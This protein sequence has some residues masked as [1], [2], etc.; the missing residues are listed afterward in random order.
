[1]QSDRGTEFV[2]SLLTDFLAVLQVR[3]RVSPA[4][5]LRV[6]G[7]VERSNRTMA[8]LLSVMVNQ[9]VRDHLVRWGE[10]Q[11]V[12][13][14]Q[15]RLSQVSRSGLTPHSLVHGWAAAEAPQRAI[16]PWSGVPEQVPVEE[17]SKSFIAGWHSV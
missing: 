12:V 2:N 16:A 9:D 7:A 1:M 6:N 13:Q 14:Y 15:M 17:S 11:P 10:F 3:Q 4:Y 5:S 8:A